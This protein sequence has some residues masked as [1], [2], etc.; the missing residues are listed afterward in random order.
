MRSRKVVL[1]EVETSCGYNDA[2]VGLLLMVGRNTLVPGNLVMEAGVT[3]GFSAAPTL[4][5]MALGVG[6]D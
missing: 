6:L 5:A 2:G 3:L 1:M 4:G